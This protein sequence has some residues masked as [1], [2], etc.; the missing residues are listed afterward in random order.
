MSKNRKKAPQNKRSYRQNEMEDIVI[1]EFS[2][3][4]LCNAHRQM[5]RKQKEDTFLSQRERW[6]LLSEIYDK[7]LCLPM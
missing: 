7:S 3:A 5:E 6:Q 4:A 1:V 2:K